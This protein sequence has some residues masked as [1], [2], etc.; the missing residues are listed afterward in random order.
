[1]ADITQFRFPT[2]IRFGVGARSVLAEFA[3]KYNVSRPLLVTDSGLAATEAFALIEGQM[4]K[5]WLGTFGQFTDVHPNP[6]DQDVD[7]ALSAYQQGK[8]DLE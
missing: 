7:N 1:M 3:K 6:T 8:C 2:D 5:V 4:N